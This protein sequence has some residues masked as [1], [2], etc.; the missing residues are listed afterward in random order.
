MRLA[1]QISNRRTAPDVA[2]EA[3]VRAVAAVLFAHAEGRRPALY[4]GITGALIRRCIENPRLSAALFRF[5]D[6]LPQLQRTARPEHEIAGHLAAYLEESGATGWLAGLLH[7][8]ARP[9]LAA[10]AQRQVRMLSQQLLAA[11]EGDQLEQL[12]GRLASLPARATIDAVGEAVLSES[13]AD[14]YLARNLRLLARLRARDVPPQL[15]LKLT[16]LSP[17]FDPLDTDGTRRRVFR[18]C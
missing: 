8:S 10:L 18:R 11:E 6:A 13:E 16:A 5:V 15:S 3:E 14:A 17:R 2:F 12:L 9:S 1:D 7:F 4:Q